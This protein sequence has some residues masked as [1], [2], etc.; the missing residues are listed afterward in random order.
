MGSENDEIITYHAKKF[1]YPDMDIRVQLGVNSR[2]EFPGSK[3]SGPRIRDYWNISLLLK[4]SSEITINGAKICYNPGMIFLLRPEDVFSQKLPAR[5]DLL[6]VLFHRKFLNQL[7]L[8]F[9][10]EDFLAGILAEKYKAHPLN[11]PIARRVFPSTPEIRHLMRRM[12]WNFEHQSRET[13]L[14]LRLNLASLLLLL[15]V[16]NLV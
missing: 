6:Q 11:F 5:I 4:G 16:L 2:K 8:D 10:E 9:G 15:N 14:L 7:G 13:D 1:F 12:L 3:Y